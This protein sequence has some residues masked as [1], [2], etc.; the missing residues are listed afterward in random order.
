MKFITIAAVVAVLVVGGDAHAQQTAAQQKCINLLN[1]GMAKVTK[2]A[3]TNARK[4]VAAAAKDP[5]APSPDVCVFNAPPKVEAAKTALNE[6]AA[7]VCTGDGV[8]T[9]GPTNSVSVGSLGHSIANIQLDTLIPGESGTLLSDLVECTDAPA[10]DGCRCQDAVLGA[11]NKLVSSWMKLFNKCKKAGLKGGTITTAADLALC[12]S[13]GTKLDPKSKG[14][15]AVAKMNKTIAAKCSAPV[16]NPLPNGACSTLTG[17]ALGACINRWARCY[18]CDNVRFADNFGPNINC[19]TF[20]DG[21]SNS[22]C[23]DIFD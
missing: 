1:K 7:T 13:D 22:S 20:D 16:T 3:A 6:A 21:L 15:K 9:I 2:T 4:C 23:V 14:P 10:G 17:D 8:P 11:S 18:I 5:A 19:E 12:L